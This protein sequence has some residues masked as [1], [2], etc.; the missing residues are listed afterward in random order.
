[1]DRL[2]GLK[3]AVHEAQQRGVD[4]KCCSACLSRGKIADDCYGCGGLGIYAC[5]PSRTK[6]FSGRLRAVIDLVEGMEPRNA[7]GKGRAA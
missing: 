1:M 3:T 6:P 2:G 4:I 5:G 7:A